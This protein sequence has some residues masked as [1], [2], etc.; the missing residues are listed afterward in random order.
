MLRGVDGC[1]ILLLLASTVTLEK[2]VF[3]LEAA[4]GS[5]IIITT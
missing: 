2:I 4:V 3:L 1:T 5:I